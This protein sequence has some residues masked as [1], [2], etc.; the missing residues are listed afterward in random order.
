MYR[1]GK[2]HGE[3]NVHI[4]RYLTGD[5]ETTRNIW[6]LDLRSLLIS[7]NEYKKKL[8]E[9]NILELEKDKLS[10][11]SKRYD[12]ILENGY[13]QNKAFKS[14]YYKKE[15]KKL[16]NRLVKYKENH[17]LYL[18]DFSIPFDNNLSE[19]DLRHVKTKQKVSG[20]W[21]SLEGIQDYL[22]IKSIIGTCKKQGIDFYKTI[23]DIY[24][25]T[26][27]TI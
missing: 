1:Y 4:S 22:D 14:Q 7:L 18:Y 27:V 9:Q 6:S 20:Y 21:T 17:L 12:E 25:G 13:R 8:M 15:E 19:R 10:K 23:S 3:C 2:R 26:P 5:Y 11:Y 16:L 24:D